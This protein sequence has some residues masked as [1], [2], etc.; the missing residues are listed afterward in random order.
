MQRFNQS[1]K[2]VHGETVRR[3][4]GS[5]SKALGRAG[6]RVP[7]RSRRYS[8]ADYFENLLAVWTH[9]G[10][11]PSYGEM[12]RAPSRI[13]SG[14]Y[15]ARWGTWRNALRA[16]IARVNSDLE[17]PPNPTAVVSVQAHASA[18]V[19]AARFLRANESASTEIGPR[20]I[21]LGFRLGF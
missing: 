1:S 12:D 14:A 19:T 9:Y 10:R 18:A 7:N 17:I 2:R 16:F 21:R 8:E 20:A 15:E 6:L 5:W 4:F 11:Q 3:R 13:S